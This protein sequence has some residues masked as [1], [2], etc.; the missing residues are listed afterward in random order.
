MAIW[1][2]RTIGSAKP[3]ST[4]GKRSARRNSFRSTK[5]SA[6]NT[7]RT[8]RNSAPKFVN[9]S[10]PQRTCLPEKTLHRPSLEFDFQIGNAGYLRVPTPRVFCKRVRKRL[11][12][13]DGSAKKSDKREKEC[14]RKRKC[15]TYRRDAE[16]AEMTQRDP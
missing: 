4:P 16:N 8:S 9:S 3:T 15:G 5:K 2:T 14:A 11:K 10:T 13:K 1:P 6:S 12:T 7:S